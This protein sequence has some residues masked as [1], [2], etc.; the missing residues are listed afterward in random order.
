M[1][2]VALLLVLA[3]AGED[4]APWTTDINIHQDNPKVAYNISND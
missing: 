1:T 2:I 4:A 3:I